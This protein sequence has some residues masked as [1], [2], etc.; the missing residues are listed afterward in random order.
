MT[1]LSRTAVVLLAA[2]R[3]QRHP[4]QSKLYRPL[5]G[6]PLGLHAAQTIA[7]LTPAVMIAVCSQYTEELMPE[8]VALGF[9]VT[10]N[11]NPEKG[12]SS[13]LTIGVQAAQ[14]HDVD[15]I[16][17]CLADMPFISLNHLRT[18]VAQL[19]IPAGVTMVG[20][21]ETDTDIIMPPAV[22]GG[23]MIEPL[24][25]LEGDRGARELLRNASSVTVTSKELTDFDDPKAFEEFGA[26]D[27]SGPD[28]PI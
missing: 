2:G 16:L 7:A 1:K 19:D 14:K 10:R 22:F 17:I 12:L 8:L 21:R 25:A 20:S 26:S 13:S 6:R 18:L 15:A 3:S 23:D 11:N 27:T 28:A 9:E 24:L 5:N 4:G